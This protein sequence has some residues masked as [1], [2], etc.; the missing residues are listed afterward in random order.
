MVVRFLAGAAVEEQPPE[1]EVMVTNLEAVETEVTVELEP[2]FGA[3]ATTA[4][5]AAKI[6]TVE[7]CIVVSIERK[8]KARVRCGCLTKKKK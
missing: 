4:A 5:A 2:F 6:A 8:T 3:A 7:N 1:Q